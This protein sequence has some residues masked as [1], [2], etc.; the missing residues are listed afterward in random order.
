VRR[1]ERLRLELAAGIGPHWRFTRASVLCVHGS[2][3]E[4]GLSKVIIC[5]TGRGSPS[6]GF[7]QPTEA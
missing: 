6:A 2:C 3:A 5:E 4:Q 7:G 1:V